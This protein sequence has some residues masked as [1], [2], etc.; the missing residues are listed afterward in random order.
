[1]CGCPRSSPRPLGARGTA[2]QAPTHP[3]PPPIRPDRAERRS[4]VEGAAAPEDGTGRGGGGEK[5]RG[6]PP[7]GGHP[8]PIVTATPASAPAPASR[9]PRSPCR[10]RC[11]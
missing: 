8:R 11:G 2:R 7:T 5:K 9:T 1:M 10:P 3:H 4:G 6:C